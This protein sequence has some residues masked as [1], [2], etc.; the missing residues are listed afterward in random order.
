[1]IDF[2]IPSSFNKLFPFPFLGG[3]TNMKNILIKLI[4][5]QSWTIFIEPM[6]GSAEI[7]LE[8]MKI[9]KAHN[10]KRNFI[11]NDNDEY[12]MTL[13]YLI[14]S[15]PKFLLDNLKRLTKLEFDT[16]RDDTFN[17]DYS[18]IDIFNLWIN[19]KRYLIKF[20]KRGKFLGRWNDEFQVKLDKILLM[21]E[22]YNYHKVCFK[23]VDYDELFEDFIFKVD[24][25]CYFDPPQNMNINIDIPYNY[26]LTTDQPIKRNN[27]HIQKTKIM[28]NKRFA[29]VYV[30]NDIKSKNNNINLN[31]IIDLDSDGLGLENIDEDML[32]SSQFISSRYNKKGENVMF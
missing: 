22:L 7:S 23:N 1:M 4:L 26:I 12:L 32:T 6:C 30:R 13:H 9:L 18:L 2:I 31:T 27:K 17:Y 16:L 24:V 15:K 8:L 28:N 25:L 3:K 19:S 20:D 5:K 11:L 10:I 14:K 21:N 29:Y